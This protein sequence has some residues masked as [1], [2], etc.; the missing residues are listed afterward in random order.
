MRRPTASGAG[1]AS[2]VQP[3]LLLV[4][5]GP[6]TRAP[7]LPGGDGPRHRRTAD[8]RVALRP[9]RVRARARARAGTTRR[10]R[11]STSAS[12]LHLTSPNRSSHDTTG[13]SARVGASTRLSAVSHASRPSSAPCERR[14]LAQLAAP[15]GAARPRVGLGPGRRRREVDAARLAEPVCELERLWEVRTRCRGR[16]PRG[17]ALRDSARSTST[18][19]SNEHAIATFPENRSQ[20]PRR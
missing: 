3:A 18:R 19:S 2:A 6:A 7:R 14:D 5:A 11:R 9:Q 15:L 8:R 17:R 13:T 12:G 4:G 20:R 10:R 1:D 16:S